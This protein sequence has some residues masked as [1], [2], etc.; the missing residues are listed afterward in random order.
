MTV[1]GDPILEYNPALMAEHVHGVITCSSELEGYRGEAMNIVAGLPDSFKG[2]NADAL[3]EVMA[4]I[5][6]AVDEG[7]MVLRLHGDR[8]DNA[9]G[10]FMGQDAAGAA[11]MR[12]V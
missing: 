10:Q 2:D 9:T 5:N 6:Q 7:Q 11:S 1:G 4:Y 3:A 8:I 12:S